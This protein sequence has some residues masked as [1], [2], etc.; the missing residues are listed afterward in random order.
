MAKLQQYS[1]SCGDQEG[2]QRVLS[3]RHVFSCISS[4]AA[5]AT[6][7]VFDETIANACELQYT[8]PQSYV[9]C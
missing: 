4:L 9:G 5:K 7:Q 6:R 1:I 2:S 3:G 8:H